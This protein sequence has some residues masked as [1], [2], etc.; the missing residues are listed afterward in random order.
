MNIKDKEKHFNSL[1]QANKDKIFRL[2]YGFLN[3]KS[4]VDDLF[5]EVLFNVWKGLDNFRELSQMSTWVYRITVNTALIYN[6][7]QKKR[8][9]FG[10]LENSHLMHF[11]NE[12]IEKDEMLIKLHK[13]IASLKKQDRLIISLLLEGLSYNEIS[14]I[15]GITVNNV[16]VRINRIKHSLEKLMQNED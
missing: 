3:N 5:Q 12:D 2:C 13:G 4:E 16:G 15:V 14:E 9:I 8:T 7:K 10:T 11:P 1:L 6:K